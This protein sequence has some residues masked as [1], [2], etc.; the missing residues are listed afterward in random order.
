MN[1]LTAA[2]KTLPLQTWVKVTNMANGR[3]VTVRINDRGPFAK[4][5]IID[6]SYAAARELTM[7]NA[8]KAPVLVEALGQ[9]KE[10][11]VNGKMQTVLVQPR[12]YNEGRFSV[13]VAS[14]QSKNNAQRLAEKLG[15]KYGGAVVVA[16][17]RGDAMFYRV[18]VSEKRTLGE[19]MDLQTRLEKAGYR[20]CF[21]VAR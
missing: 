7:V 19:A 14:L 15:R 1:D 9:P 4:N 21:V 16:F 13:Q 10:M 6:L 11:K 3:D 5:R 20:D 17:D 2:H 8:G 18:Q 12:N